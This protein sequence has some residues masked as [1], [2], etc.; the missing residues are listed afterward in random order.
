MRKY[1][2]VIEKAGDG[3]YGA[4][5]PDLPGCVGLG[6]TKAETLQNMAEAI[7][8]HLEGLKEE[9]MPIPDSDAEVESLVFVS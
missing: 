4:Y 7:Q 8:F 6:A 1:A 5:A 9:G 2:I 3:G